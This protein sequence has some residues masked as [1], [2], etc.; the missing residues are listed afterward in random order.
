MGV[1]GL[2]HVTGRGSESGR[3]APDAS[4]RAWMVTGND[5]TLGLWH[6]V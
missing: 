4:G 6:L 2:G 5:R 1:C 3:S